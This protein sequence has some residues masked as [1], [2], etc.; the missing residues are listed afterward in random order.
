MK[1]FEYNEINIVAID[2]FLVINLY[3]EKKTLPFGDALEYFANIL[4]YYGKRY[5]IVLDFREVK[6]FTSDISYFIDSL[7]WFNIKVKILT[8]G[9]ENSMGARELFESEAFASYRNRRKKNV[10]ILNVND[11]NIKIP[12]TK[13][14]IGILE[15]DYVLYFDIDVP[16]EMRDVLERYEFPRITNEEYNYLRFL[17]GDSSAKRIKLMESQSRKATN[18]QRYSGGSKLIFKRFFDIK[19]LNSNGDANFLDFVFGL[20]NKDILIHPFHSHSLYEIDNKS[21]ILITKPGIL[22]KRTNLILRKYF[23]EF[24]FLLNQKGL[25]ETDIQK[26][27]EKHPEFFRM[28]GYKE[29]YP[30]IVLEKEDGSSLIP[31]FILQPVGDEWCDLLEL[32]LPSKKI[33]VGTGDRIRF[34]K[35]V[36]ELVAQM[37]EYSAFFE[38]P[39]FQRQ[40]KDKYKLNC[41]KPKMI[42]MIG[43]KPQINDEQQFR[44]LMTTYADLKIMTFDELLKIAQTRLLI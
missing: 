23:D 42:G 7:S 10:E 39:K 25:K 17:E 26:Y 8:S 22:A 34:S 6:I 35:E 2:K 36:T 9:F 28:L 41:Y 44:R 3:T 16:Q 14:N 37:R 31:D 38:N 29:I 21:Q 24:Q 30:Q 20:N 33:A 5:T 13:L 43:Q 15:N 18:I 11:L 27:I 40:I 19:L 32:K 1:S 12:Y 4:A